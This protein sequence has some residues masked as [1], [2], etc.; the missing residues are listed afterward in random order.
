MRLFYNQRAPEDY[1]APQFRATI[2]KERLVMNSKPLEK[3]IGSVLTP[4]HKSDFLIL[5][6]DDNLDDSDSDEYGQYI[7][8]AKTEPGPAKQSL[9]KS[10]LKKKTAGYHGWYKLDDA[11]AG[12]IENEPDDDDDDDDS[13]FV[14]DIPHVNALAQQSSK[15][16]QLK[17]K[18]TGEVT[19]G[20]QERQQRN[21]KRPRRPEN[22]TRAI[23]RSYTKARKS[24]TAKKTKLQGEAFITEATSKPRTGSQAQRNS[25]GAATKRTQ[26]VWTAYAPKGAEG[27]AKKRIFQG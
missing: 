19:T 9:Q 27:F 25:Q 14:D 2:D 6:A 3:C 24:P 23:N 7:P 13:L 8:V 20:I 4:H 5:L 18:T 26:T 11:D 22:N 12:V 1:Q 17:R 15:K 21:T 10:R 16:P